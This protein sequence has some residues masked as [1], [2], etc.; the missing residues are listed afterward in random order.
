MAL[1]LLSSWMRCTAIVSYD[2]IICFRVAP[3]IVNTA[4]RG[5]NRARAYSSPVRFVLTIVIMLCDGLIGGVP[6]RAQLSITHD[7][8][9][10]GGAL[11]GSQI[12]AASALAL[13]SC[14]W[15]VLGLRRIVR[16]ER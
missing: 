13:V 16:L 14:V 1:R 4:R 11:D 6:A 3:L 8:A 12:I 10:L 9:I 2:T 7:V 15:L 5:P